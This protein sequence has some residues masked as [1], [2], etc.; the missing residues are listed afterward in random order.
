M[1]RTTDP[2]A[3]LL[4]LRLLLCGR[5]CWLWSLL[6]GL[7]RFYC[8]DPNAACFD[9]MAWRWLEQIGIRCIDAVE[10]LGASRDT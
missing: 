7:P 8:G 9:C 10:R 2:V 4:D 1:S 3:V 6:L 5:A